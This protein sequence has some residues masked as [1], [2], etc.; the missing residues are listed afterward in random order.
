MNKLARGGSEQQ[1]YNQIKVIIEDLVI[2]SRQVLCSF[3]RNPNK[4]DA[5]LLLSLRVVLSLTTAFL[6][7]HQDFRQ[8]KIHVAEKLILVP[9]INFSQKFNNLYRLQV[10]YLVDHFKDW[11]CKLYHCLRDKHYD[12]ID[13][14]EQVVCKIAVVC[15]HQVHNW[16]D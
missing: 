10:N 1:G 14:R 13:A 6:Y 9:L 5:L 8:H 7:D 2:K 11:I 4:L 12:H 16:R 15:L 3:P